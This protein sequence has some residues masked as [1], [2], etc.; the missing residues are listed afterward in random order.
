ML[1]PYYSIYFCYNFMFTIYFYF[2]V[3]E[4]FSKFDRQTWFLQ[5]FLRSRFSFYFCPLYNNK[6]WFQCF[7]FCYFYCISITIFR[8]P[9]FSSI[10]F[11]Y[12][13]LIFLAVKVSLL[14]F[15]AIL[16]FCFILFSYVQFCNIYMFMTWFLYFPFL[17][18]FLSLQS[19]R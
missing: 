15:F 6:N 17:F 9:C 19:K 13:L 5:F 1:I 4:Y 8:M 2:G 18:C 12:S 16:H 7:G 14:L 3:C 11:F 10:Q